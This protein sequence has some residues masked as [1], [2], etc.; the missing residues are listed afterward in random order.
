[1][2]RHITTEIVIDAAPDAVWRV[3]AD[4]ARY[5]HWNPFLVQI[6]G[7]PASG[8]RLHVK[9][10]NGLTMKPTLTEVQEGKVLEWL[11]RLWFGGVFDGRHRFEL[12]PEGPRTRL[13]HSESFS[14]VL[15][16]LFGRLLAQ[17]EQNFAALNQALKRQVE[18]TL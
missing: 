7:R 8:Q 13:L 14:G 1:M 18:K 9:F 5:A 11:G 6:E 2:S 10:N 15:V 12:V 4:F 17:T 3:L 16:P